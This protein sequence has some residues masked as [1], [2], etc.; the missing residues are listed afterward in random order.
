MPLL[1][2]NYTPRNLSDIDDLNVK[3]DFAHPYFIQ[4]QNLSILYKNYQPKD[5]D[6]YVATY[7]KS[8]TTW[9]IKIVENVMGQVL[10]G[11]R[12]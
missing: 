1:N 3:S 2:V 12:C 10:D 6:L 7:P 9:T 4:R 8:G 11:H 5:G